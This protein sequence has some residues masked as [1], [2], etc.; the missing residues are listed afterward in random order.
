MYVRYSLTRVQNAASSERAS[1]CDRTNLSSLYI[2]IGVEY[3]L[4]LA[5]ASLTKTD[6]ENLEESDN[7][8]DSTASSWLHSMGL[9]TQ[10]FPAADVQKIALYPLQQTP[11][12]Y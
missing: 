1:I 11:H 8:D 4:P 3:T 7:E 12:N 6:G 5:P 2:H 10:D 9:I